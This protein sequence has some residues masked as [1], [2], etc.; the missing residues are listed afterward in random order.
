MAI[1]QRV[2]DIYPDILSQYNLIVS[3]RLAELNDKMR[4]SR[5]FEDFNGVRPM[6]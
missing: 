2:V 5:Y 1:T 3:F 6:K 4:I